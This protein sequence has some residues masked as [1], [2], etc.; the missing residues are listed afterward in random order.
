[1]GAG[2]GASITRKL[3]SDC[4]L[5]WTPHRQMWRWDLPSSPPVL[6]F[7]K[8]PESVVGPCGGWLFA[9][10]QIHG[11]AIAGEVRGQLL[12]P[13]PCDGCNHSG[14]DAGNCETA[15]Y[16]FLVLFIAHSCQYTSQK[17]VTLMVLP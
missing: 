14:R 1:M 15:F 3:P 17:M 13:L 16:S 2:C 5:V 4:A 9:W 6:T 8:R 10:S 7:F 11:C 12:Q